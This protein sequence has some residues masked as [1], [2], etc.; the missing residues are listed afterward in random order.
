LDRLEQSPEGQA[1]SATILSS[2]D[3]KVLLMTDLQVR[4]SDFGAVRDESYMLPSPDWFTDVFPHELKDFQFR[5]KQTRPVPEAND[6]DD[7]ARG[8]AWWAQRCHTDSEGG[9]SQTAFAVG[10]FS[11]DDATLGR[12][13]I[14]FAIVRHAAAFRILFMEPQTGRMRDLSK[15][16]IES[17]VYFIL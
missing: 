12:H 1:L 3:L 2:T 7:Y 8:A 11:Y 9:R 15:T 14:I 16:E 10:E 13:A 6:C 4:P 17:C 5:N